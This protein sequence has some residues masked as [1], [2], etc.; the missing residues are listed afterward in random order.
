MNKIKSLDEL[1]QLKARAQAERDMSPT[2]KNAN[3]V[4]LAVGVATCGIAA[5][6]KAVIQALEEEIAAKKL[7]NVSITETGCLGYCYAEPLVEVRVPGQEPIRYANVDAK[8]A[9]EIIDKHVCHGIFVDEAIF[10]RDV[11]VAE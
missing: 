6:A 1:K 8:I 2:G 10:V 9:K 4:V 5:G 7:D 3:R 11:P